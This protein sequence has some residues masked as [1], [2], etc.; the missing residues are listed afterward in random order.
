VEWRVG[1]SAEGIRFSN[2]SRKPV[3]IS[4]ESRTTF[5]A[6][7]ITTPPNVARKLLESSGLDQTALPQPVDAVNATTWDLGLGGNFLRPHEVIWDAERCLLVVDATG[8]EA[9]TLVPTESTP[10]TTLLQLMAFEQ[11]AEGVEEREAKM[12]DFLQERCHGW[13]DNI[14][15]SRLNSKLVVSSTDPSVERPL[16]TQYAASRIWLAGDWVSS[17]SWLADGAVESACLAAESIIDQFR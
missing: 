13:T 4:A 1:I 17:S 8:G 7:V 12:R 5:D 11:D 15:L 16:C 3:I 10:G 6:L 2:K 14:Q 9:S